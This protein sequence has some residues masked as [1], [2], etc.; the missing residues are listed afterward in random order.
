MDKNKDVMREFQEYVNGC[1]EALN[2][3]KSYVT[4]RAVIRDYQALE[5]EIRA[6]ENQIDELLKAFDIDNAQIAGEE[7]DELKNR[8]DMMQ[9]IYDSMMSI[10]D[11]QDDDLFEIYI[12]LKDMY[13]VAKDE[14][15]AQKRKLM[16]QIEKLEKEINDIHQSAQYWRN[17]ILLKSD[18]RKNVKTQ[19]KFHE[20]NK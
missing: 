13:N 7:L 20:F 17:E 12:V 8:M 19:L 9:P 16:A 11:Y 18:N 6:K 10:P 2:E 1:L 15:C 5:K 4:K 14:L 3:K